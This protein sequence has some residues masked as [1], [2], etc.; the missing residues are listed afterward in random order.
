MTEGDL[1]L[2]VV[3]D[4]SSLKSFG[5]NVGGG[6]QL[7]G[8]VDIKNG[9]GGI[10]KAITTGNIVSKGILEGIKGFAGKL[11]ES[12]PNLQKSLEVLNK[13]FKLLVRPIGDLLDMFLRPLSLA[14]LR[15]AIPFYK[16]AL[17][18]LETTGGKVG[19]V[20]GA[21]G[22]GIAGAAGGAAAGAAVGGLLGPV[23]AG[24]GA[25]AG[26]A[27]GGIG[28]AVAGGLFGIDVG[29]KLEEWGK[30]MIDFF[31]NI[32]WAGLW[33]GFVDFITVTIPDAAQATWDSIIAFFT[34]TLPAAAQTAWDTLL[35]I[36]ATIVDGIAKL[37]LEKIPY[38]IGYVV[39][40]LIEFFT[41]TLPQAAQTAWDA[42]TMFFTTTLPAAAQTAWDAIVAFFT[43]TLPEAAT[44]FFTLMTEFFTKTLPE[45]WESVKTF[46]TVTVP[47]WITET[48]KTEW[49]KVMTFFSV[50]IPGWFT[51]AFDAISKA[52]EK[53]KKS[54]TFGVD[55][56]KE[57]EKERSGSAPK[58]PT[59]PKSP[60][61]PKTP[62][63]PKDFI[64]R[65]GGEMIQI[66]PQD[67]VMGFKEKGKGVLAGGG[68]TVINIYPTIQALDPS[69]FSG[70]VMDKIMREL[71][72]RL[73]STLSGRTT[74][75]MG[76]I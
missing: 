45:S 40:T 9:L 12:S 17:K 61:T 38:A 64:I 23:G 57:D 10:T 2:K 75:G 60:T 67:T 19:G 33:K 39:G 53:I 29:A 5:P 18:N 16:S 6:G 28:G 73:K 50:T 54:F 47:K 48:A 24:A 43:V 42:I 8:S 37:F 56:G 41:T 13:S 31:A 20:I 68:S 30:A 34:T 36:V 11:V 25:L 76:L 4:T 69:A 1:Q 15:F 72:F 3:F 63:K 26:G 46:F 27:L 62:S 65:P 7:S 44:A 55:K 32:D 51:S 14:F 52:W 58:T 70:G 71:E 59:T 22:G 49:N 21:V 35:N 74:Q 66:D